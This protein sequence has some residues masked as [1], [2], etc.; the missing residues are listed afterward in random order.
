MRAREPSL[1]TVQGSTGSTGTIDAHVH[2]VAG[3][4]ADYP[5]A[6]LHGR[7]S[8][9][10]TIRPATHGELACALEGAGIRR[11]VLV[12]ASSVYGFD[13][14]YLLESLQRQPGR[15][16]GVAAVD[17]AAPDS[18]STVRAL[19]RNHGVAGVRV[20]LRPAAEP[21][22][23]RP[24][25]EAAAVLWRAAGEVGVPIS[26]V[27]PAELLPE[28]EP[29]FAAFP[30]VAIVIDHLAHAERDATS[31]DDAVAAL[32]PCERHGNVHHKLTSSNLTPGGVDPATLLER[33][34][35]V[36]GAERLLWGSNFPA[37]EGTP[38]ELLAGAQTIAAGLGS[39]DREWFFRRT[40]EKLYPE[41]SG[42]SSP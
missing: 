33:L 26:L 39:R 40:A 21:W 29:V 13:N 2:A 7:P 32:L 18:G 23:G 9:W 25:L 14:S 19:V 10:S 16:A 6:P 5:L 12:Q 15:F 37:S 35:A 4:P 30:E 3:D 31:A 28:V 38:R 34:V 20:F 42:A 17:P 8:D 24:V 36:F 41:L 11:A 22:A 1:A 27:T